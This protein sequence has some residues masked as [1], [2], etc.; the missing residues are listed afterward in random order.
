M[1]NDLNLFKNNKMK[2]SIHFIAC[3]VAAFLFSCDNKNPVVEQNLEVGVSRINITPEIGYPVHKIPSD[4]VLDSLEVKTIVFSQAGIQA[5]LVLADL[6]YIPSDLSEIVRRMASEKTGIP[7][8]N[9]CIAATHTHADPTCYEEIESYIKSLNSDKTLDQNDT[10]YA[11][12]LINK[13]ITSV[14]EAKA[15]I[16]PARL[17]TGT[18]QIDGL[19]F[20]RRHLMK[21]GVVKMNGGFLN[22]NIIRAVGPTDPELG[23]VLISNEGED[24][25]FAS[26]SSFAMQLAT[27]GST[28][29]FS[30]GYPYFMEQKLKSHF[31]ENHISIFGEGPCADVNHWDISKPGPQIGYEV[32]TR[33]VGE[34]LAGRLLEEFQRFANTGASFAVRSKVIEVPL[35]MYSEMDLE[36]AKNYSDPQASSLIGARI[37]KILLL[38]KLRQKYGDMLPME[39]QVFRID[40]ETA[41]IA[42]PGQIFVELG[43]AIKKASPF[44]NNILITL[45]NSHE[46][47]IPL[48]KAYTEGSYEIVYSLVESGGGEM[49]SETALSLLNEIK[50][51]K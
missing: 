41:I 44:K 31:G 9:I 37:R 29:K 17:A 46:D 14:T 18:V 11:G 32:I 16:K 22:P 1:M 3:L 40:N 50:K 42:L 5:A 19:S 26:F 20:N 34:K 12:Q 13:L 25:P 6:F 27:I 39:V 4:G 2:L 8:S 35:Q 21:D 49:L 43:L 48:K 36:W 30:S 38:E 23:V 10:R 24:K 28:T 47:C 45:A 7:I 15:Q 33:P 51:S